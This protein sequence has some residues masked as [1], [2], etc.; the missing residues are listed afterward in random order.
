MLVLFLSLLVSTALQQSNLRILESGS[1]ERVSLLDN[2]LKEVISGIDN[3]MTYTLERALLDGRTI[4]TISERIN[5]E[6]SSYG[7]EFS[8][9]IDELIAFIEEDQTEISFNKSLVYSNSEKIPLIVKPNNLRYTHLNKKGSTILTIYPGTPYNTAN[10][11]LVFP[12]DIVDKKGIEWIESHTGEFILKLKVTG[13]NGISDYLEADVIDYK[14]EN[15]FKVALSG[16]PN[17]V[18]IYFG[19]KC[20][21]CIEVEVG[22]VTANSTFST[23]IS[24]TEGQQ[25]LNY[26]TGLYEINFTDLGIFLNGTPRLL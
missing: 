12:D 16:N 4:I 10:V 5:P 14:F 17:N 22:T 26:P 23:N 9:E 18:W 25:T 2:S 6:F 11:S 8:A 1:L 19:R 24:C 20:E 15:K 13:S 3:G 21:K 7:N